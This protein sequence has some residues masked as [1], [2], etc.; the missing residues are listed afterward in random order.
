MT[1]NDG[2]NDT[3]VTSNDNP[4]ILT[5][6]LDSSVTYTITSAKYGAGETEVN[7]IIDDVVSYTINP[8]GFFFTKGNL[9]VNADTTVKM[10]FIVKGPTPLTINFSNDSVVVVS[11]GTSG[12]VYAAIT[13]GDE[14]V[15]VSSITDAQGTTWAIDDMQWSSTSIFVNTALDTVLAAKDTYIE[16]HN[17]DT[18]Y[19][20]ATKMIIKST[21][22]TSSDRYAFVEFDITTLPANVNAYLELQLYDNNESA[23]IYKDLTLYG[24]EQTFATIST[25]TWNGI[26]SLTETEIGVSPTF[27][28]GW[29]TDK[30]EAVVYDIS[31]YLNSLSGN[32]ATFKLAYP[33]TN[34]VYTSFR[35]IDNGEA[36][37]P[38]ILYKA[39][40]ATKIKHAE[41]P[42]LSFYPNPTS[43]SLTFES[44]QA[45]IIYNL[46][47]QQVMSSQERIIDVSRLENGIYII[48]TGY[49]S[50]R[51]IK[52]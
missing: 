43:H 39:S 50:D 28:N 12:N 16:S 3:T 1:L 38:K 4:V 47:G 32:T 27:K 9:L 17:A 40:T 11:S 35:T 45:R 6:A 41:K 33:N 49:A 51:F 29:G 48:R 26:P 10:P 2:S 34:G 8:L 5:L 52:N 30:G 13:D 42:N 15:S 46:A 36:L 18:D 37:A 31:D 7:S 14:I 24:I 44:A 25:F 20:D 19:S 22:D 21:S 23:S